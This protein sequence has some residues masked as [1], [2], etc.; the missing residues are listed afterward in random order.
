MS[1]ACVYIFKGKQKHL[2]RLDSVD[3]LYLEEG[4]IWHGIAQVFR[5]L[6]EPKGKYYIRVQYLTILPS[7]PVIYFTTQ[8]S[9]MQLTAK[10][11]G[12]VSP[13]YAVSQPWPLVKIFDSP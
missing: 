5:Y 2:D 1:H 6:P 12:V 7:P 11:Q 4:A 3:Y 8:K 10:H 9:S 13:I